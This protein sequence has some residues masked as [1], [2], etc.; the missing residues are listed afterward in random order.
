MNLSI[1]DDSCFSPKRPHGCLILIFASLFLFW[2]RMRVQLLAEVAQ[3]LRN[4]V[5][6][7]VIEFC[8]AICFFLNLNSLNNVRIH[9]LL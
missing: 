7:L 3:I 4:C 9:L 8:L 1:G 5:L 2:N 6:R